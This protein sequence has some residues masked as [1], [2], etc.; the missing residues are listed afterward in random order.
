MTMR[1]VCSFAAALAVLSSPLAMA[2]APTAE[3]MLQAR[4]WAEARFEGAKAFKPFFSFNYDGRPSSDLLEKWDLKRASRRLDDTRTERT[5][6][7]TDSITGLVVRCVGVEYSDY[8]FVEWTV[9]FKNT[10]DKDTPIVSDIQ[11]FDL[12]V[13]RKPAAGATTGEFLLHHNAGSRTV[14]S[15]YQ[16]HE[17][18]LGPE[19]EKRVGAIGGRSTGG[20]FSYFNLELSGD[21]GIVIAVGWPGQWSGRFVRDRANR[22]QIRIG[23]ELTHFKLLPGEEIR[24]PLIAL[25]FWKGGDWLRAQNVWRRWFIAHN[26]RRLGGKL[27][28]IQWCGA[29]VAGNGL[30]EFVTEENAKKSIDAYEAMGL[31][32]DFWWMDAGWYPC[33]GAWPNTG[34]WEVDRTRFPNGI[35][36]IT[37]YLHQRGIKSILWFEPERATANT[38]VF[39]NHPEWILGGTD[40]SFLVN[41]GHPDAWK[42]FVNRVDDLLVSEGI[43]IY[44]QDFNME[45]LSHWRA[46]DA[47]DRQG[48]TEMRHVTGLLAFWDEL[49]RR[50]PD[51]LY[52]NCASGGRRNDLESMRRG[53]PYTKSDYALEPVGVQCETYGISLWLPYYAATWMWN[54]DAYTCRSNMAHVTGALLKPNDKNHGK[55]LPNRLGEWHT[56]VANFYGDFWPLTPYSLGNDVWMAWQFDRPEVGEGVVQ[57]FRRAENA[58]ESAAFRLRGL[59]PDAIYVL[60]NLDVVGTT[61]LAGRELLDKGLPVVIEERPGAVIITYKRTR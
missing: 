6:A 3:E 7:F 14:P 49:I 57:A 58:V 8:P 41:F 16:P 60:T 43:D 50:H 31:K 42:W 48:M 34:T 53:V 18:V 39:N 10:S 37:D 27:P 55:Q 21:E 47:A 30:M 51:M 24:T 25:Q 5:L 22:L 32:P 4:Q 9:F 40:G 17:T 12:Q 11:A 1:I 13:E 23:Q 33:G 59:D 2:V 29:T 19:A 44:R 45:P 54:E 56:T 20:D 38:W 52:D 35:R 61:E 15:D 36:A 46:D 28:P 26:L